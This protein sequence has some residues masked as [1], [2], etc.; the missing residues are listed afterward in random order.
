VEGEAMRRP[1]KGE[2]M[3]RVSEAVTKVAKEMGI[4]EYELVRRCKREARKWR[5]YKSLK[6]RMNI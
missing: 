4:S 6:R 5:A 2:E 3:D 1:T